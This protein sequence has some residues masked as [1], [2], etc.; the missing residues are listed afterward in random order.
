MSSSS[1]VI[2]TT[3]TGNNHPTAA[4][5]R[6]NTRTADV[7]DPAAELTDGNDD[8]TIRFNDLPRDILY[9]IVSKLP[10]KEFVRTKILSRKWRRM[11][12]NMCPRLT[13]DAKMHDTCV[14]AE[15]HRHVWCR[16]LGEVHPMTWMNHGEKVVETLEVRVDLIDDDMEQHIDS[17]VAIAASSRT[18]NLTL[19]LK[20][21]SWWHY[22]GRPFEFP[23]HHFYGRRL[24]HLQ[25][26]QLSFV[27][28]NLP[29]HF[30]GFP[31]LRKLHLMIPHMSSEELQRVLS[32]CYSLEW[33]HLDRCFLHDQELT[34][35]S[36]LPRLLY[37]KATY[38]ESTRMEFN[39]MNLVTFEYTGSYTPIRLVHSL[40]LQSA[41]IVFNRG[42]FQHA[43]VSLLN[44]IPVV[45]KLTLRLPLKLTFL[46]KQWLWDNP[47]KFSNLKHLQLLMRVE[48]DKILY[49][50]A[51]F[52]RATPFIEKLEVH[53]LCTST[54]FEEAGPY[55]KDDLRECKY[56]YLKNIWITGFEASRGQLEF[57]SHVVENADALEVLRV[58]IGLYPRERY[59]PCGG[60]EPAK[61]EEAK[62]KARTHLSAVLSHNVSFE[63][64]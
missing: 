59:W 26:M 8:T 11:W 19:D 52:L 44:G 34:V 2:K 51:S 46:E 15:T 22:Y 55:K 31:N 64:I 28:L 40:K 45:Q 25:H 35:A 33:L 60:N 43:L 38:C 61:A 17:W 37:L 62:Q 9:T 14:D 48:P 36:P 13:F 3:A 30:E 54:W 39:A 63:F 10:T 47:Q 42:V 1:S 20:P 53:Y 56:E 58:Y 29:P 12:P 16:F 23:F 27:S 21:W 24:S 6:Q 57:L 18:K 7:H 4:D 50:S 32:H 5:R 49:S 41:N